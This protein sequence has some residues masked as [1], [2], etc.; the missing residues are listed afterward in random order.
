MSKM[1][2]YSGEEYNLHVGSYQASPMAMSLYLTYPE[3]DEIAEILSVNLGNY[4]TER[5]DSFVQLGTTY[6]DVNNVPGIDDVL[7]EQGLC[8]PY[9]VW[10]QEQYGRSGFCEYPL[11]IFNLKELEEYD[12][13]GVAE[14]KDAWVTEMRKEQSSMGAWLDFDDEEEDPDE[15]FEPW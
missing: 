12:P 8:E 6:L 1:F 11:V 10:G 9:V 14:Y 2:K 15:E 7:K 13:V 5:P 3:D 4:Q